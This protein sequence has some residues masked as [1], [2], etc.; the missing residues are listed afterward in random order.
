[1]ME[2]KRKKLPVNTQRHCQNNKSRQ[3]HEPSESPLDYDFSSTRAREAYSDRQ[4]GERMWNAEE[5]RSLEVIC[6]LEWQKLKR[7]LEDA[8]FRIDQHWKKRRE[9]NKRIKILEQKVEDETKYKAEKE[10]L[11]KTPQE[12]RCKEGTL[13]MDIEC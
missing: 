11:K 2:K 9:V 7:I 1:M 10:E 6:K 3:L 12:A 8:M 5:V 4:R 13:K